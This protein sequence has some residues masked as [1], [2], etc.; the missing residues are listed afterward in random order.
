MKSAKYTIGIDE[1]GRGPLA[2]PVFVGAVIVPNHFDWETV[3]GVRD[4]KKLIP[5]KREE[6]YK[7]LHEL[8]EGGYLNFTTASSSA[9]MI[10]ERGIVFAISSALAECLKN[11]DAY[12]AECEILLDGSLH[13][14]EEFTMQRTII[15]G[16][17]IE[18]VI[19]MASIVAKVERDR[20][21]TGLAVR[22]P[23]Y[24]FESH[25]GYGTALHMQAIRNFG[26]CELHRRSFCRGIALELQGSKKSI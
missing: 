22:F 11:I 20:L 1:V 15:G 4:S 25:K 12:P 7:K 3:A 18:P 14:P 10:D 6:W 13:A 8:R 23:D 2:G 17:D 5:R 26:M 21:M 16:D 19:S 24:G 9:Q